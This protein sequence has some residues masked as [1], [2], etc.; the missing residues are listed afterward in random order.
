MT[1]PGGYSPKDLHFGEEARSKLIQGLDK[2][3][4]AVSST[5]GP[6]G[7]TVLIESP[8]HTRGITVTKDGVT[9][10]KSISLLDPVENLAV[11]MVREA[12]EKTASRAGDGTTTAIVIANAIINHA[13]NWELDTSNVQTDVLRSF[14]KAA[15]FVIEQLHSKAQHLDDQKLLDVA[16]ISCNN[17]PHIGEIIAQT[18][19]DVGKSGI[20]TIEKSDSSNTYS[21]TTKGIKIDRG[22]SSHLFI[23]D[24]KKDQCILNDVH[25]LVCDAEINNI[26]AI[27]AVLKPIISENKK[28]LIVAPCSQNVINTLA[29]NVMKNN[30][31]LC[32]I[33]PPNFGYKQQELMNDIAL[34]VGATYFSESTGDDLSLITLKDLGIAQKVIVSKSETIIIK[35]ETI[36]NKDQIE[37]RV[38]QLRE[39]EKLTEDNAEKKFVRQ[40]I[41]TLT[42]AIGVIHVGGATDLEQKELYDR[43]D[44]AVHAVKAALD[45]GILPG[46]GV[47]LR[48]IYYK[49]YITKGKGRYEVKDPQTIAYQIILESIY[50]PFNKIKLNAGIKLN[51]PT[52]KDLMDEE[53]EAEGMGVNVKTRETGNMIEMGII[54]PLKV[55]KEALLNAVAVSKSIL[56]T[57]AI[58]TMARTYESKN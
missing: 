47:A 8:D 11:R 18:Y 28:L 40:R 4:E 13:Y 43:V 2:L 24:H 14:D 25:V 9:V 23:N 45:E 35:D 44:D 6:L 7:Q 12:A 36:D 57:N 42:G 5:L 33:I 31:K 27:E 21:E 17:D 16:T 22:Y 48:D 58:V 10:A 20:V 38:E 52:I 1:Q 29:A 15:N 26:L 19:K 34:S 32:T 30:L 50:D 56:S 41:A 3:Y 37:E 55:T 39:Q 51:T 46:G 49:H 54:D 53:V